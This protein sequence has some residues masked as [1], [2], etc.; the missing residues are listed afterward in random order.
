MPV[1]LPTIDAARERLRGAVAETPCA[2]SATLSELT[3]TRCFIKL[4]NLP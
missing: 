2:F 3:G 4:E 1:D